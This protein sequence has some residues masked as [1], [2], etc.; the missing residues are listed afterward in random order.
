MRVVSLKAIVRFVLCIYRNYL[1]RLTIFNALEFDIIT[2]FAQTV[3][4]LFVKRLTSSLFA[5][6]VIKHLYVYKE[7][8]FSLLSHSQYRLIGLAS[9]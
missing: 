9:F 3:W 1:V 4:W 2:K 7:N 5:T 6:S 8:V